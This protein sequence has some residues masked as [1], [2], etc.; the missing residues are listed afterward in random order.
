MLAIP[1]GPIARP[2]RWLVLLVLAP[3]AALVPLAAHAGAPGANP[4]AVRFT[5]AM[6][7]QG[8]NGSF[9]LSGEGVADMGGDMQLHLDLNGQEQHSFDYIVAG[10]TA[11]ISSDG[12]PYEVVTP[13]SAGGMGGLDSSCLAMSSQGDLGDIGTL[14][15]PSTAVQNL[16]M[17][18][19]DG[20]SVEHL[21]IHLDLASA[22]LALAPLLRQTLLGC[23]LG[24][25]PL[26]QIASPAAQAAFAGATLD[27]DAYADTAD[28]F[29]RRLDLT[30]DAPAAGL[31]L[32]MQETFTPLATPVAITPPA[33][34]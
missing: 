13:G 2:L 14:L 34:F 17:E 3:C 6:Q 25:S 23:G 11:Y 22:A 15:G 28:R 30:L 9:S 20:A 21:R 26:A 33:G 4:A 19:L 5:I 16:G 27:L 7:A 32:S 31:S 1:L 24:G 18:L 8:P 29:P 12:A 10:G